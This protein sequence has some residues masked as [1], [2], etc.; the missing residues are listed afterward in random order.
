MER[1]SE[2]SMIGIFPF[3]ASYRVTNLMLLARVKR[4]DTFKI[5]NNAA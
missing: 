5:F 3:L 2:W 4:I 1:M